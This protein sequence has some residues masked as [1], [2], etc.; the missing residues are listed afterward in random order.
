MGKKADSLP[1]NK[2]LDAALKLF[3]SYF[4][5][6]AD[7]NYRERSRDPY[8]LGLLK[9]LG[10][11]ALIMPDANGNRVDSFVFQLSYPVFGRY[12][13]SVRLDAQAKIDPKA[14]EEFDD[15]QK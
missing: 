14:A 1:D 8:Y 12:L 9:L 10:N 2:K 15:G 6:Q 7:L 5:S 13:V 3:E 4:N 11:Q